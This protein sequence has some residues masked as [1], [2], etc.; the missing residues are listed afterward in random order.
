MTLCLIWRAEGALQ[1]ASDSRLRFGSAEAD[2]AIKI[3]REKYR[4]MGA[5]MIGRNSP[6]LAEGDLAFCFAGSGVGASFMKESLAGVLGGMQAVQGWNDHS[7]AGVAALVF[8]V[9][10]AISRKLTA[11]IFDVGFVDLVVAGLCAVEGHHRAFRCRPAPGQQ[12]EKGRQLYLMTEI[13]R[14]GPPYVLFGS[15]ASAAQARINA[16]AAPANSGD[17]LRIL[18]EVIDDPQ[19][20]DVGGSIQFGQFVG[21]SFSTSGILEV[22]TNP[23]DGIARAHYWRGALD[24]GDAAFEDKFILGYPLLQLSDFY[25]IKVDSA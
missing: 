17:M 18:K 4:I 10:K 14:S 12:D 6:P 2:I 7:F 23:D 5:G 8:E 24:L 20:G 22:A 9:Y 15:G 21:T 16:G 3:G 19:V 11:A 13:L 1:F 25:P